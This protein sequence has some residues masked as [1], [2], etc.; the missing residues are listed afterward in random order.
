MDLMGFSDS[1]DGYQ[2]A[3]VCG[4]CLLSCV[5]STFVF[6]CVCV[7]RGV[8][9]DLELRYIRVPGG[10]VHGQPPSLCE[11]LKVAAESGTFQ[12]LAA[13]AVRQLI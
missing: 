5:T 4:S 11:V 7:L 6:L 13:A 12:P 2:R 10:T 3:L 1:L 9:P 8:C